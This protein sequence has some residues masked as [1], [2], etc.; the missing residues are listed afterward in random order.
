MDVFVARQAIFDM[1]KQVVAYELLFRSN[2][3]NKFI[4]VE[5]SNPTIEVIRNSFSII[6]L[7]KVTE[8]KRAYINFD[9]V[10]L[11]SRIIEAFP[12]ELIAVEILETVE[13]N[14]EII[15]CC[16]NLKQKGYMLAL[17]DFE[18][19]EKFDELIE[20]ID[21]IK[22]DFIL[23]KGYER[24]EI[25]KRIKNKKIKFLAEK[26]ETEEEYKE[27]MEYGYS[28]FQGYFFC[29]PVIVLGKDIPSYEFTYIKLLKELNKD[30]ISITNL[31]R[32]FK[33]D[34]SLSYKLL[35]VVNSAH[36]SMKRKITSI[37]DA[38]MILGE[39]EFK[40]WIYIITLKSMSENS[41]DELI[42]MS[43]L[44]AYFGELLC[45]RIQ[46]EVSG[47]DAFLTGMFSLMDAMMNQ[48]I[49]N[50]LCELPISQ[51]IKD[52]LLGK[53]NTYGD[54]LKLIIMYE[55]GEWNQVNK[56]IEEIGLDGQFVGNCYIEAIQSLKSLDSF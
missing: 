44:R 37:R 1:R 18:Y 51:D 34:V 8:G 13:P 41:M 40:K 31:E 17:D 56:L 23:T 14:E 52:A 10:L 33:N 42:K 28:Y 21:I 25:M 50:I 55:K 38:V 36:Y 30:R 11:K 4:S 29:V 35:K 26:V 46:T 39:R 9:E 7:E 5:N 32:L 3:I 19:D 45:N 49:E 53:K 43:L 6:G 16:K 48:P 15:E 22:V 20:Y 54:L 2:F 24:K 12:K 27:A 47:F